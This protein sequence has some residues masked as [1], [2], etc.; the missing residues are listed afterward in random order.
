MNPFP[1]IPA[2]RVPIGWRLRFAA[3]VLMSATQVPKG[4]PLMRQ[5][6]VFR[7]AM[8]KRLRLRLKMPRGNVR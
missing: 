1:V 2:V 3:D 5:R 6:R 8:E 7:L 4:A